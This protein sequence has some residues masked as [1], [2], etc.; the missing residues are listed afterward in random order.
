MKAPGPLR[1][2]LMV[3]G[4]QVAS[5]FISIARIKLIAVL[6][7]PAGI[8]LLGLLN[9]IKEV[10]GT[11]GGLG[12]ASSGVRQIAQDAHDT[13]AQSATRTLLLV[14]LTIQGGVSALVIWFFREQL[15]SRFFA[16]EIGPQ[17]L[18]I[19]AVAVWV[20][21]VASA[22][23]AIIQAMRRIAE[24][25]RVTV[26]GALVG[27]VLGLIAVLMWGQAGLP[28]VV[29]GLASGQLVAAIWFTR[30]IG[31]PKAAHALSFRT[32]IMNWWGM[33]RLGLAFM[34]GALLTAS[35]LLLVRAMVQDRLGLDVL[36]QFEAAW[37][38][39]ITYLGFVLNAMAADY[40]PR[41]SGAVHDATASTAMVNEQLQLSLI[42]GG[43]LILITIGL[44]PLIL[45]VLYSS[46]FSD[47]AELL[48]IMTLGNL[49]KL[50]SWAIGFTVVAK[51]RGTLFILL[52]TVFNALFVALVW[53]QLDSFGTQ[54]IGGAFVAA[55]AVHLAASWGAAVHLI[56]FKLERASLYLWAS[57]LVAAVALLVLARMAPIAGGLAASAVAAIGILLGLRFLI[58]TRGDSSPIALRAEQAFSRVGWEIKRR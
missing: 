58:R 19:V 37:A 10:G 48:Q 8:G 17:A 25:V 50:G 39:T 53:W 34:F 45:L 3:G 27:T 12:M 6:L 24:L 52:E 20:G 44:A 2:I 43:P 4:S 16:D 22:M 32:L 46:H 42:L 1:A 5:I 36:G 29:L 14:S 13:E 9:N 56:G 18:G 47:A 54:A 35:T 57:Y 15:A 7:G 49:L 28:F 33:A 41:L 30:K 23:T 31:L 55:Y 21:L 51:G 11:A 38:L 26:Y 40:F